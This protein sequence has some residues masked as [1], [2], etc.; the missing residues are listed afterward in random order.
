MIKIK[1]KY[2]YENNVFKLE[3]LKHEHSCTYEFVALINVLIDEI[4]IYDESIDR[5]QLYK[6]IKDFK[7]DNVEEI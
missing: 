6:L 5:K 2:D 1:T 7:M 4:L 3:K